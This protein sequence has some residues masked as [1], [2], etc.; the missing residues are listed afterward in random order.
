MFPLLTNEKITPNSINVSIHTHTPPF[1]GKRI[2]IDNHKVTKCIVLHLHHR[3]YSVARQQK[4]YAHNAV[5]LA[6]LSFCQWEERVL[7]T[8]GGGEGVGH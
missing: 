8:L 1:T 6:C 5:A 7:V 2:T 4:R 3:C